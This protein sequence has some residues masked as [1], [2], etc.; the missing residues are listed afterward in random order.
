MP[1]TSEVRRSPEPS[2]RPSAAADSEERQICTTCLFAESVGLCLCF[3]PSCAMYKDNAVRNVVAE[4]GRDLV[5]TTA[6]L[7]DLSMPLKGE[8]RRS[9]EQSARQPIARSGKF[10]RRAYSRRALDCEKDENLTCMYVSHVCFLPSW[11]W[12][13]LLFERGLGEEGRFDVAS[14]SQTPKTSCQ[15]HKQQLLRPRSGPSKVAHN[16]RVEKQQLRSRSTEQISKKGIKLILKTI[17][18]RKG[19]CAWSCSRWQT[20]PEKIC[21]LQSTNQYNVRS[22]WHWFVRCD[23]QIFSGCVCHLE[24]LH[25]Q[26]PFLF[27]IVFSIILMYHGAK[28]SKMT[29]NSNRGVLPFNLAPSPPPPSPKLITT[30]RIHMYACVPH[31]STTYRELTFRYKRWHRFSF[32]F[33]IYCTRYSSLY[34]SFRLFLSFFILPGVSSFPF[35]SLS[36]S[37]ERSLDK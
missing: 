3:L 34:F 16:N 33:Y 17:G 37:Q 36:S 35:C 23:L 32:F 10:V 28:M 18:N 24:Q 20:Q 25:A 12:S 31:R 5:S 26:S 27:P 4:M 13:T 22:E 30:N 11:S 8:V 15:N 6:R 21:K 14:R 7:S 1:L 2:A 29:K 19:D 9:P